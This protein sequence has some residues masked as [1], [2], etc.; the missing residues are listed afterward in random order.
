MS[1]VDIVRD[2]APVMPGLHDAPTLAI[3]PDPPPS[4]DAPPAPKSPATL[5]AERKLREELAQMIVM[6]AYSPCRSRHIRFVRRMLNIGEFACDDCNL[7]FR[8]SN[9]GDVYLFDPGIEKWERATRGLV[10]GFFSEK[11]KATWL[12]SHKVDEGMNG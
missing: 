2:L 12:A 7:P 6:C 4:L 8:V 1:F 3:Q 11:G 9:M 10:P 5:E